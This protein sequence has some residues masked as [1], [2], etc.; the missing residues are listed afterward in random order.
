MNQASI[1][2]KFCSKKYDGLIMSALQTG[3]PPV[4]LIFLKLLSRFHPAV[5]PAQA[6][7]RH[8]NNTL[9]L[10]YRASSIYGLYR[11]IF[12]WLTPSRVLLDRDCW[13]H[14]HWYILCCRSIEF[15]H[16]V[17]PNKIWKAALTGIQV[18]WHTYMA[19]SKKFT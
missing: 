2:G 5:L 16:R 13:C 9:L 11:C 7:V 4:P 14:C 8:K 1:K 19:H 10:Q 15:N 17:L 12:T 3:P 18:M 6:H